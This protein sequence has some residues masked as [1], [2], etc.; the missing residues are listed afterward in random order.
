MKTILVV[1]P[2][3]GCGKTTIATNLAG[4]YAR[5]GIS[6][7]LVD[8]DKQRSAY[9]WAKSRPEDAPQIDVFLDIE[10][11]TTRRV[12]FDC[13]A[14]IEI[15]HTTELINQSDVI[16]MPINPS[17]ID[18]RAAFKFI[19]EIRSMIR[20]QLCDYIKIGFVA[21]RA[22][23]GFNSYG[24]L[25][26]FSKLMQTPIVTSLRNSQNYVTAANQGLSIFDLPKSKVQVDLEQWTPIRYWA[27]GKFD[28]APVS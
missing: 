14:G 18:H 15:G 19:F 8:M 24:E 20:S 21:N 13:P 9:Q 2:K 22:S 12:I 28:K 23:P 27:E 25:E 6:V 10:H 16:I 7:S 4:Y 17:I 11:F 3:G 5:R 1:N 26:R